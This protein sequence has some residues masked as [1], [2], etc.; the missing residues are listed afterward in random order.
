[1]NATE[2]RQGRTSVRDLSATV[3]DSPNSFLTN[4]NRQNNLRRIFSLRM[5]CASF[6]IRPALKTQTEER[7]YEQCDVTN[8]HKPPDAESG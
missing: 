5:S 8:S 2:I 3:R 7:T 4:F 6:G 1:M